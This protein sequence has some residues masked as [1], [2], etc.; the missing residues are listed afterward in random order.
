M[1]QQLLNL[2]LGVAALGVS[3]GA[4]ATD[5]AGDLDA[6][7]RFD[8]LQGEFSNFDGSGVVTGTAKAI[9][10][11]VRERTVIRMKVS[12]L[13]PDTTYPTH[14]HRFP[15]DI[16]QAG[17]HYKI[18]PTIPDTVEENE[19]WPFVT[20]D[21][22][23]NGTVELD[24]PHSLRGDAQSIV[25]HDPNNNNAKYACADL[26]SPVPSPGGVGR[27]VVFDDEPF[28]EVIQGRAILLPGEM[29]GVQ[30]RM[31]LRG[32]DPQGEY[33]SH[34]HEFPCGVAKGG[35]HYKIDPTI[36]DTI[37]EN[38]LWPAID[39]QNGRSRTLTEWDVELRR[40]AQSIVVHRRAEDG[41]N[42][43]VACADLR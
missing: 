4:L 8:F 6:Q 14:V 38:E 22:T 19:V 16:D 36:A 39:N 5:T 28:G 26:T 43:K 25:I 29:G 12:G 17:P 9:V 30:I 1:K 15:C 23:G 33:S 2:T 24:V 35:G 31:L 18:D 37:E 13:E 32:L 21:A 41:S 7:A 11:G 3:V 34:L 27:F 40:D 10:F 42:P 20:S